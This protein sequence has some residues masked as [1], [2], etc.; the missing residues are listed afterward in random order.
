MF[1]YSA[2]GYGAGTIFA[3]PGID[4]PKTDC[5]FK[6][7]VDEYGEVRRKAI[8]FAVK[9]E[10]GA[11]EVD[12]NL[13]RY[14][15]EKGLASAEPQRFTPHPA[16][17]AQD[18]PVVA[19]GSSPLSRTIKG[20]WEAVY[21]GTPERKPPIAVGL[22][23]TPETAASQARY[24]GERLRP[25]D[26]VLPPVRPRRSRKPVRAVGGQMTPAEAASARKVA[27]ALRD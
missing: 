23:M 8:Q 26:H 13:G 14:L 24:M 12:D 2:T 9:F 10:S 19:G 25:P 5:W 22:P 11:A 6:P 3:R 27:R 18:G 17:Q 1:V 20:D 16:L 7:E 4:E 15:L 21:G